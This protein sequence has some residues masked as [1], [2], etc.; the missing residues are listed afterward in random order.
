MVVDVGHPFNCQHHI[1]HE[2]GSKVIAYKPSY[3]TSSHQGCQSQDPHYAV[4][5]VLLASYGCDIHILVL[6]V[7]LLNAKY[8]FLCSPLVSAYTKETFSVLMHS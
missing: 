3:A 5:E 8:H 4:S 7:E 2:L 1:I 6:S